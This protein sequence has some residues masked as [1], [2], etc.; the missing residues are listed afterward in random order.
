[1]RSHNPLNRKCVCR[2][3]FFWPC[4]IDTDHSLL[5]IEC[6]FLS[7]LIIAEWFDVFDV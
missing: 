6:V 1:M 4:H 3:F 7:H 2:P 5:S